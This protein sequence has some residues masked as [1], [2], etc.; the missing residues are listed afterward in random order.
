M[1]KT[2]GIHHISAIVG[3]AQEN[4]NF[5]GG[6]LGMRLVKKTVNFD[7]PGTYHLYFGNDHGSPGTI[8][9]FFPWNKGFKGRIGTGQVGVTSFAIPKGAMPFWEERFHRYQVI[10]K[11][12]TRFNETYLTFED[13][14]GLQVEMVERTEGSPSNWFFNGVG[15]DTGIKGFAGAILLSNS[16]G[17]TMGLLRSMGLEIVGKEG[18]YVR[19]RSEAEYGNI[20]D[21]DVAEQER[22]R[23]GTGTVHHIAWRAKDKED[24][25]E[26]RE[27][28]IDKGFAVTPFKDRNYFKAIYFREHGDILFEIATDSPGFL[29][30]ED[31][32]HLGESL[33]LP[34]E[35]ESER[36]EIEE[37]LME[38]HLRDMER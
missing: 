37:N 15:P 27:F 14:H 8:M 19:Y 29:I 35:Y 21:V 4:L 3:N 33:M 28:L 11:K 5:Y 9:T 24:Q 34:R 1:F 36:G 26:A 31:I 38:I 18:N 22:G 16:P 30:D 17:H 20:I 32:Q 10:Y 23:M 25:M 13:P 7:D 2:M 6:V 12:H